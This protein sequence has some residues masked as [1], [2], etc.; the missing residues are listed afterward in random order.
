MLGGVGV[1]NSQIYC[2]KIAPFIDG[3]VSVRPWFSVLK[4]NASAHAAAC[5]MEDMSQGIIQ[6]IFWP[7]N[8]PNLSPIEAVW[9]MMKDYIQLHHPNLGSG[10]QHTPY[11]LCKI[12][13]EVW[14]SVSPEDLV[15]FIESEPA[16][17]QVMVDADGGPIRF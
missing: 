4:D 10:K 2:E 13:K 17:C 9:N 11:S 16:L 6:Q 12:I 3:M 15:K 14:D 7:A 5:T 8:S 1:Y